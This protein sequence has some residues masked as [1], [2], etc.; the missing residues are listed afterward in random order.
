MIMGSGSWTASA[1]RSYAGEKDA[2]VDNFGVMRTHYKSAQEMYKSRDLDKMLDP[3]DV[4]RE[5]CDS[6]EH[7]QTVPVI[8]AIDVTGSMGET[9]MDVANKVNVIMTDLYESVKDIEF[10]IMGIGDLECDRVPIQISQFESDIRISKELDK[11][12]F[13]GGGGGNMYES[14]SAA[15]YMGSRHTS[16]DC[17]KRGKKGIIITIGDEPLNPVLPKG[18]LREITGDSLQADVETKDLYPEAEKKFDIYHIHVAHDSWSSGSNASSCVKSFQKYLPS[19]HVQVIKSI[20]K[21]SGQITSIIKGN[22]TEQE[23]NMDMISPAEGVE[24]TEGFI[25][26]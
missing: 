21:L 22:Q 23:E 15:W 11:L 19:Q 1:F 10:C 13:E 26:W 24:A 5:C 3:Y 4:M 8:L 7:P 20:D 6:E 17:W 18:K 2:V 25:S 9:A 12:Y 14:Y 16:L